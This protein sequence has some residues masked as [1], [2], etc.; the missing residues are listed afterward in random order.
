M[1]PNRY[2]IW[3]VNSAA[4]G[5]IGQ[6]ITV[7][8]RHLV[9]GIACVEFNREVA[10]YAKRIV[11]DVTLGHKTP[12]QGIQAILQEQRDLLNQSYAVAR[13]GQG[14]IPHAVERIA[15]MNLTRPVLRPDPTRLLRFV[16]AQ[17]LK[18]NQTLQSTTKAAP[19]S[20][21]ADDLKFF[22]RER[23]PEAIP[24][25]QE[26]GFYIVPE[27]TTADKLEAQ[28]FTTRHPAVIAKFKALNPN[29]DQVKAGQMIVLSDPNNLQCTL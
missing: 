13:Q 24:R 16:H 7:S 23:W 12:E 3:D 26:P 2:D 1:N 17:N 9:H 5:L 11:D 6:A 14:A 21:P 18:A 4:S 19:R 22:P 10:Y 8:A 25:A 15:P 27:S 28:L 29:L 20:F